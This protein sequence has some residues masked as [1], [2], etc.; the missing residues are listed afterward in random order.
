M[1]G[2]LSSPPR[3]RE[4]RPWAVICNPF[5]VKTQMPQDHVRPFKIRILF[6]RLERLMNSCEPFR[7][8]LLPYLYDLLDPEE[9]QEVKS[10]LETCAACQAALERAQS[11]RKILA[12][13]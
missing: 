3:V 5:G 11:Q 2:C 13:A 8:Q 7:S 4:A 9:Q 10:H 1:F 6:S 12:T